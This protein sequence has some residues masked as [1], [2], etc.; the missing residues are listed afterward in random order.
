MTGFAYPG[1]NAAPAPDF[2]SLHPGYVLGVETS[3]ST[4]MISEQ[5]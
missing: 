2:A 3:V 4:A 1:I 5:V